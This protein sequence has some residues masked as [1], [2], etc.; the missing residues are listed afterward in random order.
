MSRIKI[1]PRH[2]YVSATMVQTTYGRNLPTM[3]L[4]KPKYSLPGT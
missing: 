4:I 2:T 1:K 3:K